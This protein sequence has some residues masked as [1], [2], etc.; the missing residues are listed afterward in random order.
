MIGLDGLSFAPI[1]EP[2]RARLRR[3]IAGWNREPDDFDFD[4]FTVARP[5][6]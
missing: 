5:V 1:D 2:S 4:W 6:T 3:Q